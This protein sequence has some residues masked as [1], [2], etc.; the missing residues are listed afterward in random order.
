MSRVQ[1]NSSYFDLKSIPV[2]PAA[3]TTGW[4]AGQ[5]GAY[6]PTGVY[7][8]V[9]SGSN[10]MGIFMESTAYPWNYQQ[11]VVATPTGSMVTLISGTGRLTISHVD[12]VAAGSAVRAYST[13]S[14][15]PESAAPNADLWFNASGKLSTT[16]V[17]GSTGYYPP[18]AKLI[19]VPSAANNYS[20]TIELR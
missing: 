17:S 14:G 19:T 15:N 13:G 1:L 6:D 7:G 10:A 5:G 11:G 4:M 12:E 8:Q 3:L 2:L 18:F 9:A 16:A 20:I